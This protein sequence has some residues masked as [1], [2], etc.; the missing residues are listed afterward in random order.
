MADPIKKA[1]PQ[2]EDVNDNYDHLYDKP[3]KAWRRSVIPLFFARRIY[4]SERACA[5][6]KLLPVVISVK[7]I[8]KAV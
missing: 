1:Y 7:E 5:S 6:T 3:R 8:Y 4:D 2:I